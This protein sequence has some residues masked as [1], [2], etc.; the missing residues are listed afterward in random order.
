MFCLRTLSYLILSSSRHLTSLTILIHPLNYHKLPLVITTLMHSAP[1]LLFNYSLVDLSVKAA[2]QIYLIHIAA[3]SSHFSTFF[4]RWF[5]CFTNKK[6]HSS[7]IWC[8]L[9]FITIITDVSVLPKK[10]TS[11]DAYDRNYFM[12]P[13]P[14]LSLMQD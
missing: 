11:G 8:S 5:H 10:T 7:H 4:T 6:H 9:C 14:Q 1:S 13:C 12:I 2:I 3:C